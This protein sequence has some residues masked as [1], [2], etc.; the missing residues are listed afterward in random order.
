MVS[1]VEFPNQRREILRGV[2]HSPD[3]REAGSAHLVVFPNGG[4]MGSEGDFRAH[5]EIARYLTNG[6]Y[7]VL[8]FSPCGLGY[9]D[10]AIPNSSQKNL[11]GSIENGLFVSDVKA[12]VAF[13]RGLKAFVTITLSGICGGAI[14]SL[15]AAAE[16]AE[17]RYVIPVGVPVILDGDGKDYHA[18]LPANEARLVLRT[19]VEKVFSPRAWARFLSRRSEV[20][21]IRGAISAL[22]RPKASY[23]SRTDDRTKFA[24]NPL[25]LDA[26]TTVLRDGKKIL[27]V[28]GD[29]DGFWWEFE[30]LFLKK[31][32]GDAE[33]APFDIYR[34][35][36]AN[37]M[38]SLREMQG[39]VSAAMLRW[40]IR[41]HAR[42]S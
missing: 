24:D 29:A 25:F 22:F 35:P 12:A 18:R 34:S 31:E 28:F 19:Y 41:H 26:V 32:Y 23:I 39:D 38:L 13:A 17:V 3:S 21:K 6:G 7:H 30:R 37:H 1:V 27:F 2:L 40:M 9:S 16:I 36:R 5:V 15:L 20:S 8:R 14:T 10:G 4:V 42:V 33:N 11:Y